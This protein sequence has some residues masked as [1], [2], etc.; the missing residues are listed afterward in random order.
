MFCWFA[1]LLWGTGAELCGV[2]SALRPAWRPA[3]GVAS[4]EGAHDATKKLVTALELLAAPSA[5]RRRPDGRCLPPGVAVVRVYSRALR[6]HLIRAHTRRGMQCFRQLLHLCAPE[7]RSFT[8]SSRQVRAM[9]VLHLAIRAY[10]SLNKISFVKFKPF[11][12]SPRNKTIELLVSLFV[13]NYMMFNL[14]LIPLWTSAM[15]EAKNVQF[16]VWSALS[17]Y[18]IC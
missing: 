7:N 2:A 14:L 13:M 10:P 3:S 4:Q 18:S 1:T 5:H 8:S 12:K 11:L 16:S 6:A 17:V 9:S 15:N